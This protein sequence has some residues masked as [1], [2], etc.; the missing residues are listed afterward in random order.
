MLRNIFGAFVPS[1]LRRREDEDADMTA[2]LKSRW[3]EL[4]RKMPVLNA[5]RVSKLQLK[6]KDL[7]SWQHLRSLDVSWSYILTRID[8]VLHDPPC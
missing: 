8:N 3:K 2:G 5:V 4:G 7:A 6:L 1:C